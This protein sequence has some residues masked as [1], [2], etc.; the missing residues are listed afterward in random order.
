MLVLRHLFFVATPAPWKPV[1]KR[2]KLV[3]SRSARRR[4]TDLTPYAPL[5]CQCNRLLLLS[6]VVCLDVSINEMIGDREVI[7]EIS[8][9]GLTMV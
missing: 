4:I 5:V 6:W 1:A 2:H 9:P 8:K 7:R 3:S